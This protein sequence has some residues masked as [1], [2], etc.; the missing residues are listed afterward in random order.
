MTQLS[1]TRLTRALRRGAEARTRR[2]LHT[3]LHGVSPSRLALVWLC[4]VGLALVLGTFTALAQAEA[5]GL[6][7]GY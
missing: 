5:A 1:S 3:V 2:S 7:N 4:L 6:M